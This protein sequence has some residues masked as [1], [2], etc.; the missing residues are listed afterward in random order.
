MRSLG[1][2]DIQFVKGIGE[3]R[4]KILRAHHIATLEDLVY[5]F[6]RR[7]LDRSTVTAIR[8]LR[9][10]DETTVVG[11]VVSSQIQTGRKDRLV[12]LIGDGTG[13]LQCVWFNMINFWRKQF[14]VGESVSISGKVGYFNGFQIAH[15]DFDKLDEAGDWQ[16]INTGVIVPMYSSTEALAKAGFTS[17]GFRKLLHK[18]LATYEDLIVESLPDELIS[19]HDLISLKQALKQI[20]YPQTDEELASAQKR[21]KFD[22]LFF[23]E[24]MLAVR[25]KNYRGMANGISFQ[26]V[27]DRTRRLIEMLDFELTTAQRRVLREIWTDMKSTQP[28]NRLVQGDVG[29][30]KTIV[31]LIAM[32]MAVENGYQAAMMAPTEILAEQHYLT[33]HKLLEAVD[34]PVRLLIGGLPKK[35]REQA[36][37]EIAGGEVMVVVGTHALI[38]PDVHYHN[39]GMAI[40]DEQHRFGVLQRAALKQKGRQPDVLVMTATPIPRT[41]SMTLYGDLDVS[42]IDELPAG[43]KPVRTVS[44]DSR[45]RKDVYHYVRDELLQGA[46]A[47]IVFPL[48][49]ESEKLDLRAAQE[50]YEK[51]KTGFFDQFK[52]GLLHGRMTSDEKETVMAQFKSAELDLL[53][54]TTVIEVGVD[55]ANATIMVIEHADRFGLTQL[56]QLRGRVGR[57]QKESVCILIVD[58][59]LSSEARRR[60]NT[61]CETNDGFRIAEVDLEIRGPGE[62]FGTRQH[63]MPDL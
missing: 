2:I 30:G 4:A 26:D 36:L 20:H 11:K 39:L 23:L 28:M 33:V 22:E 3:Y 47:Y 38:Q 50:T 34:V 24:L 55:V 48:V 7:Y 59:P 21:L 15:P 18:T 5:F 41:L 37:A 56:H 29:S 19:E 17:K 9:E 13:F 42:I 61:M 58:K 52:V 44:R 46:Q 32:L 54:A 49:E 27:G 6:P 62:F 40:V 25:R 8:D 60:V 1:N 43:R 63:G 57:G 51:V 10:G 45:K 16:T 35:A 53:I 12:V 31:A 14:E